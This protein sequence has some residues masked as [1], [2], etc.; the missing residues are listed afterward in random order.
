MKRLVLVVGLVLCM[1]GLALADVRG[2]EAVTVE[3]HGTASVASPPSTCACRFEAY[4]WV[5]ADNKRL[6]PYGMTRRSFL[7]KG[8]GVRVQVVYAGPRLRFQ[9]ANF[10]NE[11]VRVRVGWRYEPV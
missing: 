8:R 11:A 3:A 2:H 6:R 4:P 10:N 7:Y 1:G 5:Y 9:I